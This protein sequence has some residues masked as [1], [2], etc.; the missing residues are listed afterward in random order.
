MIPKFKVDPKTGAI[1]FQKTPEEKNLQEY[2][3]G[4]NSINSNLIHLIQQ[5][6]KIIEQNGKI[7]HLLRSKGGIIVDE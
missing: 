1:I 4:V 2:L 3:E 5:N 6:D 7:L